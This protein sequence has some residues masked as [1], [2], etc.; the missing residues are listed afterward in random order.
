MDNI[1]KILFRQD[2]EINWETVNPILSIGEPG[3]AI[4]NNGN[5]T[6][7]KLGD[8]ITPWNE[9]DYQTGD[10]TAITQRVSTLETNYINLN[11]QINDANGLADNLD[12]IDSQ[13][14][15]QDG[16][17]DT[18]TTL[19]S[20]VSSN[21]ENINTL[22]GQITTLNG[23]TIPAITESI[24]AEALARQ[25]G[26]DTVN[27]AIVN[28]SNRID[29]LNTL[30]TSPDTDGTYILKCVVDQGQ[31]TYQWVEEVIQ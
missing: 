13:I 28:L 2:T 7:F 27:Q 11:N 20:T 25:N 10:F 5:I 30:P 26:D 21:T 14:N 4:D 6:G 8:G 17:A 18:L 29:S 3:V 24:A 12:R 19:N 1:T 15:G 16:I 22:N 23:T 9:L 31:I